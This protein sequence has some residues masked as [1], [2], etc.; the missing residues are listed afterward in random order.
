M[1]YNSDAISISPLK[2]EDALQLNKLLVS[3]TERFI[4][5]LPKTLEE[6]TTLESTQN[7][8]KGKIKSAEKRQEFVYVINDK[9]SRAMIG[10]VI[11][12]HLDWEIKQGEF[13]YCI[14]KNFKG[15]GF[16][17]T[18]IKAISNYA[19][20]SLELKTLQILAHKSN[21]SSVNV[22]L[23]SGFKWQSTLNDEFKPLN[24][25]SLDME[26]FVFS[27]SDKS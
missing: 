18:A 2:L 20:E 21:L 5:F 4:R 27:K 22:A 23:Q 3:N 6:N 15:K 25:S 9:Y 13:A 10:M 14:S 12:K 16:M 24:E 17:S 1:I 7:Y 26:L 19:I 11:L 8:I